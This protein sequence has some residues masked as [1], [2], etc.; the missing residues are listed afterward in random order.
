MSAIGPVA[1]RIPELDLPRQQPSF[2][3]AA[4]PLPQDP[5]PPQTPAV[6]VEINAFIPQDQVTTP[7]FVPGGGTFQG[8]NRGVGTDGT[9]RT[10]QTVRVYDDPSRSPPYRVEIDEDIGETH[11]LDD[12]GNVLETGEASEDDL[13]AEVVEVR[14]DGT[15]VVEVSGQSANPLVGVAPGITYQMRVEMRPNADGTWTVSSQGSH[16]AFPGY[17]VLAS[18]DGGDQQVVYGYDPRTDGST[19]LALGQGDGGLFGLIWGGSSVD[20]NGQLTL[21]AE[22]LTPE[23]LLARHTQGG[24]VDVGALGSDLAQ[25]AEAGAADPAFVNAVFASL[26]EDQRAAAANAF[27]DNLATT[28]GVGGGPAHDQYA[29]LALTPAGMD[30]ILA[31][32]AYAPQRLADDNIVYG[33]ASQNRDA[34]YA[35]DPAATDTASRFLDAL[36]ASPEAQTDLARYLDPLYDDEQAAM[37]ATPS[38]RS[39]RDQIERV[40]G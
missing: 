6:E 10:Q 39:L 40:L 20:A 34:I 33:F 36:Q 27:F 12:N 25:S 11:K 14:A 30:V 31:V 19:P 9:Q 13:N 23:A 22:R 16:D 1:Q 5:P 35:G 21:G 24:V 7:F 2:A 29:R 17:E 4:P 37:D 32:G 18:V 28:P 26:P 15:I 3:P 38:G 8:D